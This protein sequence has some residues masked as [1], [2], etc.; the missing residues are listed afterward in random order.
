MG[1]NVAVDI[2]A[3]ADEVWEHASDLPSHTEWMRDA[4][5]IEFLSGST[6]GV[7]TTMRVLT[8]VGPLKTSDVMTVTRWEEPDL[9]EVRHSGTVTGLGRFEIEALDAATTRFSWHED[10]EMPWYFGGTL[11][12]P[13]SERVLA[14]I[15]KAN[16]RL[17]KEM[18][19]SAHRP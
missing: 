10:L 7:G 19:E 14:M 15:W 8:K 5:A 9:I 2:A 3:P 12:L 4:K 16:L 11:G 13:I 18:V 1:V 6:S 17:F